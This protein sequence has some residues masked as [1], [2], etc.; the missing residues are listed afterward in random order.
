[1]SFKQ[2]VDDATDIIISCWD[3]N[4][5]QDE[6]GKPLDGLTFDERLEKRLRELEDSP[7]K[8]VIEYAK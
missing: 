3:S 7:I 2:T 5:P 6:K 8:E 4:Q 1:M